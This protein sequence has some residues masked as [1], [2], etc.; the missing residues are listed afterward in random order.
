MFT[1]IAKQYGWSPDVRYNQ[2]KVL[3]S[4]LN[5]CTTTTLGTPKQWTLLTGGLCSEVA[6]C[7]HSSNGTSKRWS[8]FGRGRLPIFKH[9]YKKSIELQKYLPLRLSA[10]S[11]QV[12]DLL[13]EKIGF[14]PEFGLRG[15]A[16]DPD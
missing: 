6:L 16:L 15:H 13:E 4:V 8:L 1:V 2:V 14:G 10:Q 5:L 3:R 12:I 7:C 11:I 9:L